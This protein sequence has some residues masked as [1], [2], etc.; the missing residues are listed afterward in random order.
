MRPNWINPPKIDSRDPDK[1]LIE[2]VNEMYWEPHDQR[3]RHCFNL[4]RWHLTFCG[5]LFDYRYSTPQYASHNTDIYDENSYPR[6]RGTETVRELWHEHSPSLTVKLANLYNT[7]YVGIGERNFGIV[8]EIIM[9]CDLIRVRPK[10]ISGFEKLLNTGNL[11]EYIVNEV[12][13]DWKEK[14]RR[15]VPQSANDIEEHNLKGRTWLHAKTGYCV[16]SLTHTL[17][18][19]LDD[20]HL[21]RVYYSPSFWSQDCTEISQKAY[22][23]SLTPLWD[24]MENLNIEEMQATDEKKYITGKI[25]PEN[26]EAFT[27]PGQDDFFTDDSSE[28]GW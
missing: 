8:G 11:K 17:Y 16:T 27:H 9:G 14:E 23:V 4:S 26:K 3:T 6:Y 25:E 2:Q 19:A 10:A 22:Q 7:V 13:D 24:F 21:I 15:V 5:E 12:K 1:P 28:D 18:T 20:Q